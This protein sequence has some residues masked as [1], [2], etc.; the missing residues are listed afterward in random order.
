MPN[1]CGAAWELDRQMEVG[2]HGWRRTLSM[3]SQCG[4]P[5]TLFTTAAIA[6]RWPDLLKE[7]AAVH[8]IAS[9]GMTHGLLAPGDLAASRKVLSEASGSE[10]VGFRRARMAPT[11]EA[12]LVAAGYLYD[13]SVHPIWLPGRYDNR[14]KPR[15]IHRSGGLIE[16]PASATPRMRVPVFWLAMKHF[17]AWLYRDCVSR[18]LDHD[19]YV[20][21]YMHPWEF[22]DLSSMP[23]PAYTRRP[24]G[25]RLVERFMGLV[26]WLKGRA[27]FS[28][29]R[30]YLTAQSLLNQGAEVAA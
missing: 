17:P 28:S 12:D 14:A 19:G 18:C 23:I 26:E 20:N 1:E 9:H 22:I 11:A 30:D 6:S 5:V 4:V 16:V 27:G 24:C 10:V 15:S 2:A 8:E 13:S 29:M 3:L 25:E 7:S 21:I